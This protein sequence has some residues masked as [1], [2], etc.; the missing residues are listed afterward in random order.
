MALTAQIAV[1]FAATPQ[2]SAKQFESLFE[3]GA[4]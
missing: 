4:Q 3:A 1:F 2:R